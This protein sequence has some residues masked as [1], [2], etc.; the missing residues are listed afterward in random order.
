MRIS[1]RNKITVLLA[2]MLF[3]AVINIVVV[4]YFQHSQR[5][6]SN[7]INL[8]GRQRMLTQRITKL[9]FII[10]NGNISVRESL[11]KDISLYDTTLNKLAHSIDDN[12]AKDDGLE[13]IFQKNIIL[14]QPFMKMALIIANEDN[15]SE[16]F[17]KAIDFL[18]INN[19]NLLSISNE[20]TEKFEQLANKKDTLLKT[21]LIAMTGLDFLIFIVGLIAITNL[22]RPFNSLNSAALS[23]SKGEYLHYIPVPR[24][25]DEI[26]DLTEIFNEMSLNLH[27]SIVSKEFLNSIINSTTEMLFVVDQDGKIILANISAYKGIGYL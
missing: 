9:A 1:L 21:S 14:W 6:D 10:N 11:T 15:N 26:Y 18:F 27:K 8:S 7:T 23:I 2:S 24:F 25:K 16:S 5:F 3:I 13:T 17:K 4:F 20:M 22:L 12:Q 19:D